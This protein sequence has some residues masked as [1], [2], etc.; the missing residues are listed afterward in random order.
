M[1]PNEAKLKLFALLKQNPELKLQKYV[2]EWEIP[3]RT[4]KRWK[5]EYDEAD[6]ADKLIE[7]VNVDEAIIEEAIDI[8]TDDLKNVMPELNLEIVDGETEYVEDDSVEDSELLDAEDVTQELESYKILEKMKRKKTQKFRDALTGLKM[9]NEESQATAGTI[10]HAIMDRLDE[11][12]SVSATFKVAE[13][14]SLTN[15]LV[16]IQNAFFNKAVTNIQINNTGE[17]T[18]SPLAALRQRLTT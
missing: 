18:E 2:Q 7:L 8:V 17:A 10:L 13:I 1:K 4:L 11:L 12:E 16:N 3:L 15:S 5:K 6:T 14:E 9:L